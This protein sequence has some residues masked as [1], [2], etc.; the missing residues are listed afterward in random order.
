MEITMTTTNLKILTS[1]TFLALVG[2]ILPAWADG[3]L[4][5]GSDT[6]EFG[7]QPLPDKIGKYQTNGAT[8]VGGANIPL[9]TDDFANGMTI[10]GG[11]LLTGT[12]TISDLT[13]RDLNTVPT[14][15]PINADTPDASFNEDLA[16]DGTSIWRAY[17]GDCVNGLITELDPNNLSGP[18]LNVYTQAFG[19]VGMTSINGQLWPTD[20][21]SQTVGTFDPS[22]NT[23]T[24]VFNTSAFGNSGCLGWDNDSQ[25][26]WVGTQNGWVVPYDM[27]GVQQGPAFQPFGDTDDTI[28]GCTIT[29]PVEAEKTWT[30]TDYNWDPVCTQFDSITGECIAT[31]PANINDP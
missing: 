5:V 23:Y 24:P 28:D 21:C 6:E 31:R 22:T 18:A 30:F 25:V 19:V 27:T 29:Q 9:G 3:F 4:Y 10:V 17:F 20:W 12:V 16:Y 14:G 2:M 11:N 8:I 13:F 15:A 26:L 7:A 1:A